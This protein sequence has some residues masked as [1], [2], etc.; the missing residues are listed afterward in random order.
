MATFTYRALTQAGQIVSGEIT[1]PTEAEVRRRIEF[2]GLMPVET[3][4]ARAKSEGGR[5]GLSLGGPKAEDVTLFT[6]D[7]ALLLKAGARLD[8]ALELLCGDADLGR[9]R[10]VVRKLRADVLAGQSFAEAAA[11]EPK[12]FPPVYVALVRAVS[13]THLTLPTNREV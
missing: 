6:R 9:M 8:E 7:L 1:A 4:P 2:L 10:A 12:L 3:A 5:F 11:G 13:Y